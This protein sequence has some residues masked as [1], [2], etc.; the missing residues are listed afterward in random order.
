MFSVL[1]TQLPIEQTQVEDWLTQPAEKRQPWFDRADLRTSAALLLLEQAALRRQLL[2]AQDELKRR[3]LSG[4]DG[5]DP[6][7]NKAGGALQQILANSGFLSRPAE[8]LEGGYGLPQRAEWQRLETESQARQQQLRQLSDNLDQEV[9]TL[10]EPARL[11]ELQATEAQ[12]DATG[13]A[14]AHAAQSRRRSAVALVNEFLIFLGQ[15]RV[16]VQPR[17][18]AVH[19]DMSIRRGLLRL[20]QRRHGHIQG[21]RTE[22]GEQRQM[23]AALPNRNNACSWTMSRTHAACRPASESSPAA[24]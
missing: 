19:P 13:Q 7:V 10:L 12:P 22:L 20:V 18:T 2:L 21:L 9:R 17:Q 15:L 24:R 4:R 8:L 5:V 3:Y 14:S 23:S 11:T 16:E 1:Q 6:T